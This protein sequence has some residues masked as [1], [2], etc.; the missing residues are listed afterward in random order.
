[1]I[2]ASGESL[3]SLSVGV[4]TQPICTKH[5]RT[6]RS[7]SQALHVGVWGFQNRAV[8]LIGRVSA[9]LF[10]VCLSILLPFSFWQLFSFLL[11]SV[12]GFCWGF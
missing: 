5:A 8:R 7:F 3:S 4:G 11:Y 1:M 9:H 10:S 2:G 6:G 12:A